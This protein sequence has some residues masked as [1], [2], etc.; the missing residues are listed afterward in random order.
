MNYNSFRQRFFL[1]EPHLYANDIDTAIN[2]TSSTD[3]SD[4]NPTSVHSVPV[5]DPYSPAVLRTSSPVSFGTFNPLHAWRRGSSEIDGDDSDNSTQMHNND[6]PYGD[7]QDSNSNSIPFLDDNDVEDKRDEEYPVPRKVP[8]RFIK[9]ALNYRVSKPNVPRERICTYDLDKEQALLR[10]VHICFERCYSHSPNVPSPSSDL[11]RLTIPDT[12]LIDGFLC[13]A[14]G[15]YYI[16]ALGRCNHYENSKATISEFISDARCCG[17]PVRDHSG[18]AGPIKLDEGGYQ[19]LLLNGID[20]KGLNKVMCFEE[21]ANDVLFPDTEM[22]PRVNKR[23]NRAITIGYTPSNSTIRMHGRGG[24]A[25]PTI[26][27]GTRRYQPTFLKMTNLA[28]ELSALGSFPL[29]YSNLDG[30]FAKR[31]KFA[32]DIVPGNIIECLTIG[33]YIHNLVQSTVPDRSWVPL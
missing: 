29:P 10:H 4:H 20:H 14:F 32:A 6:G 31:P 5:P 11:T 28:R 19:F 30:V 13:A 9:A 24:I 15:S 33:T 23:C 1:H 27:A 2:I 26:M 3:D 8:R 17:V 21:V 12:E 22:V 16:N 25:E 7:I 18:T